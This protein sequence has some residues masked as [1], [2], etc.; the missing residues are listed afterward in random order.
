MAMGKRSATDLIT[1]KDR[2][3]ISM[4]ESGQIKTTEIPSPET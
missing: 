2:A 4:Q 1:G 3:I